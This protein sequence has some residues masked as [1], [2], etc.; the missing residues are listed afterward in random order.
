M[1]NIFKR[2]KELEKRVAFLEKSLEGV[3]NSPKADN[4]ASYREVLDQWL[5]GK[6]Q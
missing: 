2:I 5:N 1:I 4:Q 6:E 3:D